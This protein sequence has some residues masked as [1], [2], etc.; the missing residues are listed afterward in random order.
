MSIQAVSWALEFQDL[1][2]DKRTG[3]PSSSCAFVLLGLANH[4]S[5]DGTD[6]FPSIERLQRY[7]KLSER[8]VQYAL[9][10]LV[11]HGTIQET[12]EPLVRDA[13]IQ[14]PRARPT[15]YDIIAMRG[16][17]PTPSRG[18]KSPK[19]G[20]SR[21]CKVG[22][23]G[24][25]SRD[26]RGCKVADE[27]APE[28]S[29]DPSL[30]EPS[31]P[32]SGEGSAPNEAVAVPPERPSERP[33]PPGREPSAQARQIILDLRWPGPRGLSWAHAT[34]LAC[35]LDAAVD[36]GYSW[37]EIAR[38]AAVV[39]SEATRNPLSYLRYGLQPDQ[40]PIPRQ[41]RISTRHQSAALPDD[42]TSALPDPD[43]I[44]A[45]RAA[46]GLPRGDRYAERT[47]RPLAHAS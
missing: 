18:A 31:F 13:R 32:P 41:P 20:R 14:D 28:P 30:G 39:L 35:L 6:S 36:A 26:R 47:N 2:L 25:Q 45:I 4:A 19:G 40:L 22:S 15:S 21:G 10:A 44:A 37:P 11:K 24:V 8:A 1:P 27:F 23:P 7:T 33:D 12:P 3:K 9:A 46:A 38:H 43:R 5:E 17:Q 42:E 34:E 29:F 16:S